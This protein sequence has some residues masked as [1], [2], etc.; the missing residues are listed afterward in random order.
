VWRAEYDWKPRQKF[1][2]LLAGW[3]ELR[4]YTDV[5][6]DYFVSDGFSLGPTWSP[7]EKISLALTASYEDQ[8]YLTS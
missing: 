8:E 6:S 2:L 5:E 7:T 4:A 1:S 3:R